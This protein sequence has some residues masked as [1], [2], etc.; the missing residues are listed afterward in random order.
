MRVSFFLGL[1]FIVLS[2]CGGEESSLGDKYFES[3]DY[4][5]AIKAYSEYLNL[6][7]NNIKSLYNR[8]RSYEELKSFDMAIKD[9]HVILEI[10]AK[11]TAALLSLAKHQ[12]RSGAYDKAKGYAENAIKIKDDLAEGHF[13]LARAH[14]HL[15]DFEQA[16]IYYNNAINLDRNYGDAYLFRGALKVSENKVSSACKDFEKAKSLNVA[17]ADAAIKNH[18]SK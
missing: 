15:G 10:D 4:K 17:Q 5:N 6:H 3:R 13:W 14:H 1:V 7:P 18:C 8:G 16:N 2:S 9:F 12:Y 11:N